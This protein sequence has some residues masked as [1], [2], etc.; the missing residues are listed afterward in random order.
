MQTLKNTGNVDPSF[1]QWFIQSHV[2]TYQEYSVVSLDVLLGLVGGLSAVV[3]GALNLVL[4][5][6]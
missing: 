1:K 3:F 6:Y 4:G 5:F 2:Q